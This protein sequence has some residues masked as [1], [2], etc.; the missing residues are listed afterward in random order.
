M[1]IS[2]GLIHEA[3]DCEGEEE[4]WGLELTED[5]LCVSPMPTRRK[6]G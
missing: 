1:E 4:V 2:S 5:D 6:F 3:R